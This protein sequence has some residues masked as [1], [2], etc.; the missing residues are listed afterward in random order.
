MGIDQR[1]KGARRKIKRKG[2]QPGSQKGNIELLLNDSGVAF[3]G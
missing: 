2:R 1:C 3:Y